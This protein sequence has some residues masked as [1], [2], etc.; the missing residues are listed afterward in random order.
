MKDNAKTLSYVEAN[1]VYLDL[2][3]LAYQLKKLLKKSAKIRM[4][5]GKGVSRN[6]GLKTRNKGEDR[7]S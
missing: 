2:Y 4:L 5:G 1:H 3:L 6:E 7:K